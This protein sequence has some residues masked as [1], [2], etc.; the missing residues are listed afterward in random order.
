MDCQR[1]EAFVPPL[2]IIL[3]DKCDSLLKT[4][5]VYSNLIRKSKNYQH[6]M[7]Q[8]VRVQQEK[9]CLD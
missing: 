4:V 8:E 1:T 9:I 3:V 5:Q 7:V 2:L 6:C